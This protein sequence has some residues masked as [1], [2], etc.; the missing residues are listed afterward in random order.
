M[1]GDQAV[2]GEAYIALRA[3][4]DQFQRDLETLGANAGKYMAPVE[5]QFVKIGDKMAKIGGDMTR[6]VTLPVLAIGTVITKVAM[7]FE[8]SMNR[9][10]AITNAT[11]GDMDRMSGLAKELGRTT[12]YTASQT[13]D[14]M[15]YLALAG[16]KTDQI[17]GAMPGTLQLAASAQLDLATAANITSNV[18]LG[19]NKKV[20][21]LGHVND[22]LTK[23]MSSTNVDLQMLGES[24]KYA[25]PIASAMRLQ[26]EEVTAAIGLMG[27]VGIQGSMAG[28]AIRGALSRLV[29]PSKEAAEVMGDLGM[30]IYDTNGKIL[31]LVDI[32]RQLETSGAD[33]ADMLLIFG[34]RAGPA[35]QALVDQ[36]ADRLANLTKE[37]ENSGGTAERMAK[38]QMKGLRGALLE[39]T[40]ALEG[41]A[42][43]IA[44][45]G[46]L[47]WLTDLAKKVTEFVTKLIKT[48]PEL[49]QLATKILLVVAAIGPLLSVF[50]YLISTVGRVIGVV[51][52]L[53]TFGTRVYQAFQ[54][55]RGGAATFVEA[56]KWLITPTGLW[57][58]AILAVIAVGYLLYTH[59]DEISKWMVDKWNW[60]KDKAVA[61]WT[62]IANWFS[63]W[64]DELLIVFGG[65]LGWLVVLV[66]KNWDKISEVT[67]KVWNSISGWLG[68]K[69]EG[70]K[71]LATKIW[72]KMPE[73]VKKVWTSIYD[74]TAKV[75]NSI[76]NWLAEKWNAIVTGLERVF[77]GMIGAAGEIGRRIMQ[78]V[79]DGI[80]AIKLPV[81]TSQIDGMNNALGDADERINAVG[82]RMLVTNGI[83]DDM[84]DTTGDYTDKVEVNSR[85]LERWQEEQDGVTAAIK[86]T[87][88][89]L[90][91]IEKAIQGAESL[92]SG[93]K[94]FQTAL[95]GGVSNYDEQLAV[96]S[97]ITGK[98]LSVAQSMLDSVLRKQFLEGK[99][100]L[101]FED[102]VPHLDRGG[103]VTE[104]T[105]ALIGERR[106]E[107]V[108]PLE[109]LPNYMPSAAG[110]GGAGIILDVHDN[111]FQDGT[112]AGNRIVAALHR[113]GLGRK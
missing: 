63:E 10:A 80:N 103:I 71:S 38:Q 30:N 73:P 87:K 83:T 51:G 2:I 90:S 8:T 94:K 37:L 5:K 85:A 59:W 88:E 112:D 56:L 61:I 106:S 102:D 18:L 104:P 55:V 107:V 101:K 108:A 68:A 49:F 22:V 42:L 4:F 34:D 17:L 53:V 100:N 65:P 76:T 3:K 75:W 39:L 45:S 109:E 43:V 9:V 79:R 7:D 91:P 81:P 29:N 95:R 72:D 31:P 41:L 25:G 99:I 50:G 69:W 67:E 66:V 70:I 15:G 20:S 84:I 113:V 32:I 92:G 89:A 12:Q 28:T 97:N 23:A 52:R 13:A 74:A 46:L 57:V 54:M 24:M 14:A 11:S 60:V 96:L 44:D 82:K 33:A 21:E 105:L 1:P 19:Y 36:G 64:W 78:G 27:N 77:G 98:D 110:A 35:M 111:V 86:K 93:Y 40:S 6:K 26:F 58:A 62:G 48:N 47:Q 16:F